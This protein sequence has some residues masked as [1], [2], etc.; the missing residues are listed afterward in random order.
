MKTR[1]WIPLVA[2]FGFSMTLLSFIAG[3]VNTLVVLGLALFLFLSA[4]RRDFAA[5]ASLAL[6]TV[7][8]H[9]VILTL[10]LLILDIMWRKQWRV[11]AGLVGALLGCALVLFVLYPGWPISFWHLVTSGMNTIR[12]T[13]TL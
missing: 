12:E 8:P 4:S 1:V 6:T 10:P 3:Q 13:P 9:L 7:K 5:G 2:A 11:L